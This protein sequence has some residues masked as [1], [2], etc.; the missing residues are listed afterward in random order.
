MYKQKGYINSIVDNESVQ[1]LVQVLTV[2]LASI[3]CY[4]YSP[5]PPVFSSGLPQSD[6]MLSLAWLFIRLTMFPVNIRMLLDFTYLII[7]LFA[8]I[9]ED[10]L[11]CMFVLFISIV[12]GISVISVFIWFQLF[13][14]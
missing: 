7:G 4:W 3:P 1:F 9:L 11:V 10:F 6:A 8:L 12:S 14:F 13:W 2:L 5:F